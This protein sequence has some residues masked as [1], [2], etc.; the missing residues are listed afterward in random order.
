VGSNPFPQKLEDVINVIQNTQQKKANK[1]HLLF[2]GVLQVP[3]L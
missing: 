1:T 3:S 2:W